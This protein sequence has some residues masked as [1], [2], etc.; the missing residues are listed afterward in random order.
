MI[1]PSA[2][3]AH[4]PLIPTLEEIEQAGAERRRDQDR[5]VARSLAQGIDA[6]AARRAKVLK[7]AEETMASARLS[8]AK[9]ELAERRARV[10]E[11]EA[12]RS[13]RRARRA[14]AP[15]V[16]NIAGYAVH[17]GVCSHPVL[18]DSSR[19]CRR[20]YWPGTLTGLDRAELWVDHHSPAIAS[21]PAGTLRLT[22]DGVGL[23]VDAA[24]DDSI[25]RRVAAKE[26]GGL[27]IGGNVTWRDTTSGSGEVLQDAT[28]V[29][30]AE[31]SL[32][33]HP[34]NKSCV[35][36]HSSGQALAS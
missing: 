21:V 34:A 10:R 25:L 29:S 32:V 3:W 9:A 20:R 17:W 16:F 8:L 33:D 12:E 26:F 1:W 31:V 18:H 24:V 28:R 27:S 35:F 13:A 5:A 4:R 22:E 6:R 11:E 14:A 15:A 36:V 2:R 7:D 19:P 30:L 23:W